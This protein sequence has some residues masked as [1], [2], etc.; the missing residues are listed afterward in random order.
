MPFEL[1]IIVFMGK[2]T[3]YPHIEK[4]LRK[5][6]T[7]GRVLE[8]GAGAGQYRHI[9]K[10]HIGI[11][12]PNN[13]YSRKGDLQVFCDASNL[14]FRSESFELVFVVAALYM[15][16]DPT[17][18]LQEAWTILK[19]NGVLLIFDYTED[20]QVQAIYNNLKKGKRPRFGLWNFPEL[21]RLVY[22]AAFT[23]IKQ[24][25]SRSLLYTV[26]RGILGKRQRWLILKARKK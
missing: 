9:F 14:P 7:N 13:P 25:R 22:H 16:K 3:A 23:D 11:D 8:L 2:G 6:S 12:L 1:D 17:A 26:F 10:I 19:P 18:A 24:L 4:I 21:H 15:M 20:I 5:H